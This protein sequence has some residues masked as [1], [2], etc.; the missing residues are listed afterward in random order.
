MGI[1]KTDGKVILN[2]GESHI[3]SVSGNTFAYRIPGATVGVDTTAYSSGDLLGHKLS[4]NDVMRI[5]GG[6]GYLM[7]I[8]IEDLTNQKSAL[9]VIIFDSNPSNTTFT[10]NAALTIADADI[11]KILGHISFTAS[12]YISFANNAIGTRTLLNLPVVASG[13]DDLYACIV[14]RGT[15]TYGAN[16]LA[17]RFGFERN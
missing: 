8:V 1:T 14:C 3:G 10:N 5:S 2:S 6:S 7:S 9:D 12:D 16:E 15:P 11:P 13:S 17:I 4:L